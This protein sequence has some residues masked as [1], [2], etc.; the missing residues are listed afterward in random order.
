MKLL[1]VCTANIDRGPTGED[2]FKNKPGYEAKSAGTEEDY[3]EAPITNE[4]IEWAD[5][6]FCMEQKHR[7]R[8]LQLDPDAW[9]KTVVLNVPDE[10][11]RGHPDLVERLLMCVD[12]FI[13]WLYRHTYSESFEKAT[14]KERSAIQDRKDYHLKL[15]GED[16]KRYIESLNPPPPSRRRRRS[17][18]PLQET[19]CGNCTKFDPQMTRQTWTL[20]GGCT[21]YELQLFPGSNRA[22]TCRSY[23]PI[24]LRKTRYTSEQED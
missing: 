15:T 11:Y 10:F 19:E 12:N 18:T 16:V 13:W 7:K 23:T 5:I 24:P 3:A 2:I 8:V 14:Q 4:L 6:V 9:N 17:T 1:F 20:W 21:I 22:S